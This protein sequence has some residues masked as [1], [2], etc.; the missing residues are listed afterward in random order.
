MNAILLVAAL[1]GSAPAAVPD[2]PNPY[3]WVCDYLDTAPTVFGVMGL[4]GEVM[5]RDLD[6]ARASD[7]IVDEVHDN[8]PQH[9]PMM[10]ELVL[11]FR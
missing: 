7:E 6:P 4:L 3:A 10:G 1:L 9:D 5:D 2:P 11:V 8:C